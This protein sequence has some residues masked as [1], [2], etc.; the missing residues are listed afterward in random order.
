MYPFGVSGTFGK[1]SCLLLGL[2]FV[3]LSGTWFV[4]VPRKR[5]CRHAESCGKYSW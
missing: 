5:C 3:N 4:K 2:F 1:Q